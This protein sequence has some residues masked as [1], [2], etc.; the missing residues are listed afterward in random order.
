MCGSKER[1]TK[2]RTRGLPA[3]WLVLKTPG[4][5]KAYISVNNCHEIN[6]RLMKKKIKASAFNL[7]AV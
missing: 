2:K 6:S 4:G 7:C 1:F 5:L 3:R